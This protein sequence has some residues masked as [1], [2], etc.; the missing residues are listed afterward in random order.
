MPGY[1]QKGARAT[2][3]QPAGNIDRGAVPRPCG[4]DDPIEDTR[5]GLPKPTETPA[6]VYTWNESVPNMTR[7]HEDV[8]PM[9]NEG[10]Y[11]KKF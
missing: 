2:S 1:S 4:H 11:A 7:G 10:S 5:P 8:P 9:E 3:G 6:G